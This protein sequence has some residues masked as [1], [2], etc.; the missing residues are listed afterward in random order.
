MQ[1]IVH[2]GTRT[3]P[4]DGLRLQDEGIRVESVR[5]DSDSSCE[6]GSI[7]RNLS[8]DDGGMESRR[9]LGDSVSWHKGENEGENRMSLEFVTDVEVL[10]VK[11]EAERLGLVW[12]RGRR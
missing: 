6:E 11:E 8:G 5:V 1:R 12:C 10:I 4:S 2:Q 9:M 7:V 3:D